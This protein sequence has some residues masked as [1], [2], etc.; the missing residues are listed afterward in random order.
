[1]RIRRYI[2]AIICTAVIVPVSA[3]SQAMPDVHTAVD[4]LVLEGK[5]RAERVQERIALAHRPNRWM[6]DV[7][8]FLEQD[9]LHDAVIWY[10]WSS[11]SLEYKR[12]ADIV[13][14][15]IQDNYT[16]TLV[17]TLYQV[18][19]H[20]GKKVQAPDANTSFS[21][22]RFRESVL[23]AVLNNLDGSDERLKQVY[24]DADKPLEVRR[25]AFFAITDTV[26]IKEAIARRSDQQRQANAY[27]IEVS[28]LT[29][30]GLKQE[31]ERI[32][33]QDLAER[34]VWDAL[35]QEMRVAAVY[36]I[37]DKDRLE[38]LFHLSDHLCTT[39]MYRK[40][41]FNELAYGPALVHCGN[42]DVR[43]IARQ[44][45]ERLFPGE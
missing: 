27:T 43:R 2:G 26:Y 37:T 30:Q 34:I 14:R 17:D 5:E 32:V 11:D 16:K 44:R 9:R 7:S 13:H 21:W 4:S 20:V 45:L 19:S 40:Y 22:K 36:A 8:S 1:M 39:S 23:M 38:Y 10:R 3:G 28:Y 18:Y 29:R 12:D 15:L 24:L 42:R 33:S 41:R 25:E 35:N 6:L 31:D